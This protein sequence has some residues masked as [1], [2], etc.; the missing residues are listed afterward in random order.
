MWGLAVYETGSEYCST[1]GLETTDFKL[2]AES[3]GGF[4]CLFVCLFLEPSTCHV[5]IANEEQKPNTT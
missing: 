3:S 1:V 2:S 4:V 5:Q